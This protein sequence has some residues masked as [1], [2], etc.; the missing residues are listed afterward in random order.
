MC[1]VL[2]LN[3][4]LRGCEETLRCAYQTRVTATRSAVGLGS[5]CVRASGGKTFLVGQRELRANEEYQT[6]FKRSRKLTL[7]HAN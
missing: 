3:V 4:F 5:G 7:F 2:N 1:Q 6:V